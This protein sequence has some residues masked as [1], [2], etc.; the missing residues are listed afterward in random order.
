MAVDA[1]CL[2]RPFKGHPPDTLEPLAPGAHFPLLYDGS[3]S[4]IGRTSV[5]RVVLV[6]AI[7]RGV[8]GRLTFWSA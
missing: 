3:G 7:L 2:H 4:R 5:G 1:A 6:A 8:V